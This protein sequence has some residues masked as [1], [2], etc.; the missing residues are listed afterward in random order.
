[1]TVR[2]QNVRLKATDGVVLQIIIQQPTA[3][4]QRRLDRAQ[5]EQDLQQHHLQVDELAENGQRHDHLPLLLLQAR[6]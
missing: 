5:T 2:V 3:N 4:D 1:M 6:F